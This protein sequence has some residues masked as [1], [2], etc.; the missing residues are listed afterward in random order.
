MQLKTKQKRKRGIAMTDRSRGVLPFLLA[1]AV[2]ALAPLASPASQPLFAAVSEPPLITAMSHG[3]GSV[4][5][6]GNSALLTVPYANA[7]A[8]VNLASLDCAYSTD[9][10]SVASFRFDPGSIATVGADESVA[11]VSLIVEYSSLSD[12]QAH[13]A[14]YSIKAVRAPKVPAVFSGA[15]AK[16]TT[17]PAAAIAFSAADFA[18][19]YAQNDGEPL[20]GIT[21]TGPATAVGELRRSGAAY[22]LGE[23]IPIGDLAAL[24]F[25]AASAGT[26]AY[27]V[28]CHTAEYPFPL[29]FPG[30]ASLNVTVRAALAPTP[31]PTP[32]PPASLGTLDDITYSIS[33]NSTLYLSDSDFI[34]AFRSRTGAN[35]LYVQLSQPAS[36]FGRLYHGYYSDSSYDRLVASQDRYYVDSAPRMSDLAFVPSSGY[37]GTGRVYYTAYGSNGAVYDGSLR[38]TVD[39]YGSSGYYVSGSGNYSGVNTVTYSAGTGTPVYFSAGDFNSALMSATGYALYYVRFNIPSAAIGRLLYDYSPSS[40]SGGSVS[41]DTRYY[42]TTAP[43]L[44]RVAFVPQASYEGSFGLTYTAYSSAGGAYSGTA[45]IRIG[46]QQEG[47]VKDVE[48]AAKS[49]GPVKFNA[50]DFN[51][52]FSGATGFSLS[53]V[54]FTLPDASDGKLFYNYSSASSPGSAVS[55]AA[56]YYRAASQYISYVTFVPSAGRLS[57]A[58]ALAG[59]S[60]VS[61]RYMAYA[62]NGYSRAGVVSISAQ[63]AGKLEPIRWTAV[64][65]EP[66][67]MSSIDIQA[68]VEDAEPGEVLDYI[69]FKLPSARRGAL[70][71]SAASSASADRTGSGGGSGG[72][73]KVK[74]GDSYYRRE[75]PRISS[76]S[77]LPAEGY[78]GEA[79]IQY[80]AFTESEGAYEGELLINVLALPEGWARDEVASLAGR[81][82]IVPLTLLGDFAEPI[83][84][85]EFTALL[86]NTY[87]YARGAY[88]SVISPPFGD[89]RRSGYAGQIEKGYSLGIVNGVSDDE[90]L[91][92]SPLTREQAAKIICATVGAIEK[93]GIESEYSLAYADMADISEWALP[94]AA[95]A[96]EHGLM[97]GA[98]DNHFYP[99]NNLSREEAMALV[100]RLIVQYGY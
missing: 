75:S 10:Y 7:P 91:P 48:Y 22:S 18:G 36:S 87:E 100:E 41:P 70:Y 44:S 92:D 66:L 81:A 79:A 42:R 25:Q 57:A 78:S 77:F 1:L 95:Y 62:S 51:A 15:I 46:Q 52:A 17:L 84:R 27:S 50:D 67:P 94:F 71:Y 47:A 21:V 24:T 23:F 37:A 8:T 3:A 43:E 34:S 29:R 19:A 83:T 61:V 9:F 53:Y 85:A 28:Y 68:A 38:V 99:L 35:L 59:G 49:N 12:G 30:E 76:V 26:V 63:G 64:G 82:S 74:A 93:G 5:L 97:R 40:G 2:A 54:T 89:I 4:A 98:A 6:N 86:V 58:A 69:T 90:F 39:D 88:S 96:A 73:R 13:T 16:E 55:G 56:R 20:T 11:A 72:A 80:A 32:T 31:S 65:G 33:W 60:P 45:F 14:A